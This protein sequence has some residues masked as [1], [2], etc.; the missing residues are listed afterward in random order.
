[1]TY[2]ITKKCIM[3]GEESTLEVNEEQFKRVCKYYN[4]E[5]LIQDLLYD[6]TPE[7]REFIKSGYCLVCQSLLFGL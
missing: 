1:M 7:E 4:K 3:C 6:F 5:G 2:S